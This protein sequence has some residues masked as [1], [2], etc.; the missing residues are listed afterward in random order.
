L[1]GNIFLIILFVN[2]SIIVV[3]WLKLPQKTAT[4]TLWTGRVSAPQKFYKIA[5]WKWYVQ[6]K[7]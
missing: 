3:T 6:K 4:K 5:Q 1:L 7:M 2:V